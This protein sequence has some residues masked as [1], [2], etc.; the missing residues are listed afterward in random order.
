MLYQDHT[1]SRN[2]NF[3]TSACIS[4][5][6]CMSSPSRLRSIFY[7]CRAALST[8]CFRLSCHYCM[9]RRLKPFDLSYHICNTSIYTESPY[10]SS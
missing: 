3:G 1:D 2:F 9:A 5:S 6:S 4:R 10:V 8:S 7:V